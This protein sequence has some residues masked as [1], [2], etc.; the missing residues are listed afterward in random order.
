M[1]F[2][3]GLRWERNDNLATFSQLKNNAFRKIFRLDWGHLFYSAI[4]D[5]VF[6]ST[7]HSCI[8]LSYDWQED[9]RQLSLVSFKSY[10][11]GQMS[12]FQLVQRIKL[13]DVESIYIYR[14]GSTVS[15]VLSQMSLWEGIDA[16]SA[17]VL[18]LCQGSNITRHNI[19]C[20]AISR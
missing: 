14:L 7:Q 3:S 15:G 5:Y 2:L 11:V 20:M 18:T 8:N 4:D 1:E 13:Y 6:W 16:L 17:S 10:I 9:V 12:L 19:C